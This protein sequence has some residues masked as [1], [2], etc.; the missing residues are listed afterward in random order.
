[1]S[2]LDPDRVMNIL[3]EALELSPP[4]RRAFLDST[5]VGEPELRRELEELLACVDPPTAVF[6]APSDS[7][8]R[9]IG[10]LG[11]SD[12]KTPLIWLVED[13]LA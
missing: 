3:D 4:R 6:E 11:N 5:C 9:S 10:S 1:M 12:S 13:Q 2:R 7:S 8:S